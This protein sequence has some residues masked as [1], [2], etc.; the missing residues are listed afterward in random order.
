MVQEINR[1][2]RNVYLTKGITAHQE[3]YFKKVKR[4]DK[5][6]FANYVCSQSLAN[7]KNYEGFKI[8][9]DAIID[10]FE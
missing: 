1:S 4:N 10:I 9:T 8:L 2:F 7:E 5:Q 6:N 3:I